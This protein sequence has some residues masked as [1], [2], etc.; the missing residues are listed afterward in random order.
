MSAKGRTGVQSIIRVRGGERPD[1]PECQVEI[2]NAYE[3]IGKAIA[4]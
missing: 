4:Q 2:V 1:G 3:L